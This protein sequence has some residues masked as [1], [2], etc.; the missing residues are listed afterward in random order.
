VVFF[1][2]ELKHPGIG[3]PT[4]GGLVT[5]VV[6]GLLL[7]NPA[8]PGVRVSLW[9][10]TPVALAAAAFFAFAVQAALR[11]RGMPAETGANRL[12]GQLGTAAT[13]L[14][15]TGVVQVASE[16]WSAE[17]ASGK[18][19]RGT[20]VRVVRAEGLRLTVEPEVPA[21]P[22]EPESPTRRQKETTTKR[23]PA[24][25]GRRKGGT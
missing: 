25:A 24:T 21:E 23:T 18:L 16:S 10:I 13:N 20:R 17:V 12:V 1:L 5:L 3:L 11:L 2:L 7:F 19:P 22:S 14:D 8:V 6:G 9:T 15:P 4:V